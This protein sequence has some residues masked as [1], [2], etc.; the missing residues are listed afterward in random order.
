MKVKLSRENFGS[1]IFIPDDKEA[2]DDNGTK[3]KGNS[4]GIITPIGA[5]LTLIC[6]FMPWVSC[7]EIRATELSG[8]Q[9]AKEESAIWLIL[10]AGL[11]ILGASVYFSSKNTV[12][13]SRLYT[14]VGV[15]IALFVFAYEFMDFAT[16]I[17]TEFG[18]VKPKDV[19]LTLHF[20]FYGAVLGF[21]IA[22]IGA[23]LLPR[24][25]PHGGNVAANPPDN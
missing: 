25:K 14:L 3:G 23:F 1:L 17:E 15:A 18:R 6:F 8:L 2:K 12:G 16:G 20:G 5:V 21:I 9:L 10:I 11:V 13:K 24:G 22:A 4:S 7:A 19:G